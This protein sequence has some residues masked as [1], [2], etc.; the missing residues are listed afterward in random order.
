MPHTILLTADYHDQNCVV[1]Q[2][3]L[4]TKVES[5]LTIPTTAGDLTR[6]VDKARKAVGRG[7]RVVWVQESTTGW[8]LSPF[9]DSSRLAPRL[10]LPLRERKCGSRATS[11]AS[12]PLEAQLRL[13]SPLDT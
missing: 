7:G 6:L 9:L 4:T 10:P 13:P 3:H 12:K 5:V 11:N 1:R 2:R 8:A